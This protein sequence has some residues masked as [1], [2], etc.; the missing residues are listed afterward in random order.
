RVGDL[1]TDNIV[2]QFAKAEGTLSTLFSG[3]DFG[4]DILGEVHPE[5]QVV[6]ARQTF[7]A[8]APQPAIKLPAFA[9][10]FRLKDPETVGP[11]FRRTYQSLIGFLNITGSMNGQP[12]LNLDIEKEDNYQIVSAT[13]LLEKDASAGGLKIH[14]NFSPSIAFV[15]E[16]FV[17]SSTT[18]LAR[19]LAQTVGQGNQQNTDLNSTIKLDVRGVSDVLADNRA[20]LV[21][22]NML[23]E[24]NSKEEAERTIGDL[25]DLLGVAESA[26]I[27]LGVGDNALRAS[28]EIDYV[29]E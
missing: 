18:A 28:L 23:A 4:E 14:Y 19:Q 7:A 12:Q 16:H 5:I 27:D 1:F 9:A 26:T 8:D 22:Q 20:Q 2:D 21:A 15:G 13:Y 24:G 3:K 17:V 6:V 25:L 11:D 10:V 29:T